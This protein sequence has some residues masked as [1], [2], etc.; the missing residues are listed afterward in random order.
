MHTGSSDPKQ[1]EWIRLR[2]SFSY[3]IEG[4]KHTIKSEKNMQ[5][6]LL[7]T[8]VVIFLMFLFPL[9]MLERAILFIVIGIVLALEMVNTAIENVVDL[10]TEEYKPLAKI[11]KDVAAGAVLLFV[12]FA[13]LVGIII[14]GPK[15]IH[16][17]S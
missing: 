12:L 6:H 15:V 13:V 7:A 1:N 17:F 8:V 11:A 14:L 4:M 9:T 2:K 3:A 16:F 5:I 10:V